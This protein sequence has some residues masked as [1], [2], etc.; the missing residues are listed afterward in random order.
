MIEMILEFFDA[1]ATFIHA[2]IQIAIGVFLVIVLLVILFRFIFELYRE[3]CY[4]KSREE[5]IKLLEARVKKLNRENFKLSFRPQILSIEEAKKI[6][7]R[8]SDFVNE[9]METGG[10]DGETEDLRAML[11]KRIEEMENWE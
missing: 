9:S 3:T 5:E 2:A 11:A 7:A 10:I 1:S 6:E 8:L 4:Y